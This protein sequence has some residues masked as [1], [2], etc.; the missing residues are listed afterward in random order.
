MKLWSDEELSCC[1]VDELWEGQEPAA[2]H[3]HTYSHEYVTNVFLRMCVCLYGH[4]CITICFR[5]LCFLSVSSS[6]YIRQVQHRVG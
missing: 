1:G 6:F 2:T 3:A 5:V 4:L